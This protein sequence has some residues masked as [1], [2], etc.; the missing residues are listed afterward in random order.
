MD[1]E[2]IRARLEAER[3]RLEALRAD[4]NTDL[5]DEEQNQ[6]TELSS[7]DQHPA[8]SGT[9]TFDFERDQSIAESIDAELREVAE[10]LDRL[11]QGTYGRCEADGAPIPAER[12]EALPATR[13]CA[14]HAA[15]A[16]AS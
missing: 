13:W 5:S 2:Q 8:D 3:V 4:I 11:Q 6:D 15:E 10:A 16:A 7:V 12:L 9:E 14:A 1:P